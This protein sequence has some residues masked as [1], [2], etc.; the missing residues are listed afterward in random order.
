ML[1]ACF[2]I[3]GSFDKKDCPFRESNPGLEFRRLLSYPLDERG[4]LIMESSALKRSQKAVVE[5]RSR[6]IWR[7]IITP[8]TTVIAAMSTK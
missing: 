6:C 8:V 1:R 7:Y 4:C 2:V 3:A 5:L